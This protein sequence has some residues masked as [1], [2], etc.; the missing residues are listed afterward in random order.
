IDVVPDLVAKNVGVDV[1]EALLIWRAADWLDVR[2]GRQ[3]LTWGTGDLVF[4]NDLF[5]KDYVSFF[6]GRDDE[7][8]KAPSNALRLGIWAGETAIDL[9]WMP[10]WEPDVYVTG[11]RL[12]WYDP[13]TGAVVANVFAAPTPALRWR[14]GAGALRVAHSWSGV[15]LALY[16]YA[17]FEGQPLAF[18]P[19]AGTPEHPRLFAPGASIRAPLFG[20]LV[21]AE[22]AALLYADDLDGTDPFEPNSRIK[23]LGGAERELWPKV[24]GGLQALWTRTLRYDELKANQ[25]AGMAIPDQDHVWLTL[26]LRQQLL[27][28]R[29]TLGLFA[30]VSPTDVDGYLR[31]TINW[32]PVDAVALTAGA[33]VFAGRDAWTMFGQ[34]EDNTNVYARLRYSF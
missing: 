32:Q 33:N 16:G 8:L 28:D 20:G 22:T 5:P 17:G 25:P 14:N 9:V 24:T 2:A 7:F 18:D 29:L 30:F 19:V 12:A 26:R 34:L 4:V 1:R 15:E 3:T 6:I 10:L 31:P 27:Q 23:L 11:Q 21:Y 13:T